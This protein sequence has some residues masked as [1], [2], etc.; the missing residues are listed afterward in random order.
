M[1]RIHLA[2]PGP[3]RTELHFDRCQ[4]DPALRM[5]GHEAEDRFIAAIDGMRIGPERRIDDS[6]IDWEYVAAHIR[7]SGLPPSDE[8]ARAVARG[9]AWAINATAANILRLPRKQ[10]LAVLWRYWG[11]L[12]LAEIASTLGLAGKSGAQMLISRARGR[13]CTFGGTQV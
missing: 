10:A 11:R 6:A 13:L 8:I 2:E 1:T 4:F 3:E 7:E 9:E 5:N 12:T